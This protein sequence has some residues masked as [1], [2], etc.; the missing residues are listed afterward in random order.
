MTDEVICF[1]GSHKQDDNRTESEDILAYWQKTS[2]R[3]KDVNIAVVLVNGLCWDDGACGNNLNADGEIIERRLS[4]A[5]A[6][7]PNLA[8]TEKGRQSEGN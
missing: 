5:Q 3:P 4:R 7:T 8:V 6:W 1:E 2:A